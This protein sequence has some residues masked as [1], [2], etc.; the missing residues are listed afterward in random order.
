MC[1]TYYDAY[2]PHF[3]G[4]EWITTVLLSQGGE[5]GISSLML[6]SSNAFT[7]SGQWVYTVHL[8]LSGTCM[9]FGEP[10]TS[11]TQLDLIRGRVSYLHNGL[12]E[13]PRTSRTGPGFD[14]DLTSPS[15]KVSAVHFFPITILAEPTGEV[16]RVR[17]QNRDNNC[18]ARVLY[19]LLLAV[20]KSTGAF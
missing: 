3:V 16:A 15:G 14:F 13:D 8:S 17:S 7:D 18:V 1:H 12:Q 10:V 19:D 2:T 9:M 11:F 4:T 20:L 5:V 6:N